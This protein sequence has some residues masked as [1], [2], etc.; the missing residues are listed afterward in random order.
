MN[1]PQETIRRHSRR[2]Q[3]MTE[4]ALTLPIVLL[5]IFGIIEF[6]RIF[7]AWVTL[8]NSA[9]TAVRA[10]TT[11]SWE[12]ESLLTRMTNYP[13]Y[14]PLAG[15]PLP[16]PMPR[17][18]EVLA[19]WLPCTNGTNDTRFIQHWG[20]DC[21]PTND[22]HLG[23]RDDM[24]RLPWIVDNARQGAAGLALGQGDHIV[25]LEND[26]GQ[27][28]NTYPLYNES[29]NES[30]W[31]H[32]WIC[33]SRPFVLEK[34]E[35][36]SGIDLRYEASEDRRLRE[37]KLREE[38]GAGP[39]INDTQY[40]A[41]GPGDV[42]EVVVHFNHP[43]ITPLGLGE[44]IPLMARRVGINEAFRSTRAV[45]LPP[46]L[47]AASYT[48][49]NTFTPTSTGTRTSTPTATATI[50]LVEETEEAPSPTPE[51]VCDNLTLSNVQLAANNL[52]VDINNDNFAPFYIT[53]V[54]LNWNAGVDFVPLRVSSL[55]ILESLGS[56]WNGNAQTAPL[57]VTSGS[58]GWSDDPARRIVPGTD[59][60]PTEFA[61]PSVVRFRALFSNTSNLITSGYS[62]HDFFGTTLYF[63]FPGS[64]VTCEKP[65][66]L[67]QPTEAPT[68]T[69]LPPL[70]CTDYRFRFESYW[71]LGAVR[72]SVRNG[73][74]TARY[75][76]AFNLQ[77]Q[78]YDNDLTLSEVKI[79]GADVT[80]ADSL[81]LWAGSDTLPSTDS[82]AE[83]TWRGLVVLIAPGE[84]VNFWA[85]YDGLV[86][87][88]DQTY[89]QAHPSHF[90]GSTITI[91]GGNGP[92]CVIEMEPI[93]PPDAPT[94]TP[95]PTNTPTFTPTNTNTPTNT[96]CPVGVCTATP[97]QT[98]TNTPLPT[99]TRTNTPSNTPVTPSPTQTNT[100]TNTPLTPTSTSTN[101]PNATNTPTPLIIPTIDPG[102]TEC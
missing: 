68:P 23:L 97:T 77:W 30:E 98:Q 63:S 57:D 56:F 3:T 71:D 19:H 9:R 53:R 42:L 31:F 55:G 41:G 90:N 73:G 46:A 62:I 50:P 70:V 16:D 7:Q 94:E 26:A 93:L 60:V 96:V 35:D 32:V 6:A 45:N 76:N 52:Y 40:D 4:F 36:F 39:R 79:R 61:S 54:V 14:N 5:L 84:I 29:E 83:G 74:S 48:P 88:I 44:Y 65:L 12:T 72:F 18:G 85:N 24:A 49:S 34:P 69:E 21:D 75:I 37:C 13:G 67:Q 92:D 17:Q 78:N 51:P 25:G 22:D 82:T 2:G 99:S 10:G 43:L 33:S 47:I 38:G 80:V 81:Q 89:T 15:D 64:G 11:G 20:M 95:T 101:T 86:G 59:P 91:D 100:P 27:E 8:Q 66:P 87:Y 58:V 28:M 1:L 102:C